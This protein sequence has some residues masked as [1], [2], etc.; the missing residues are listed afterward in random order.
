MRSLE[1]AYKRQN[2]EGV[3]KWKKALPGLNKMK[4]I[5]SFKLKL[6]VQLDTSCYVGARYWDDYSGA[7][8]GGVCFWGERKLTSTF[9]T[10]EVARQKIE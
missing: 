3:D 9:F 7:R 4:I 1:Q 10:G 5:K 2:I 8:P 6:K